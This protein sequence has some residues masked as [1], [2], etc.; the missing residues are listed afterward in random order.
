VHYDPRQP[1]HVQRAEAAD[2]WGWMVVLA[3]IGTVFIVVGSATGWILVWRPALRRRHA[4]RSGVVVLARVVKVQ[5]DTS[6]EANGQN[7][8]VIKLSGPLADGS[9]KHTYY[10]EPLWDDPSELVHRGD[11]LPV[12]VVPGYPDD[13]VVDLSPLNEL[14][15][16]DGSGE[17]ALTSPQMADGSGED[18]LTSPHQAE[19]PGTARRTA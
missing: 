2:R 1:T 7:P 12:R 6:I 3:I 8:W 14:Q 5:F 17:G 9:G 15:M 18:A 11:D 4:R 16:A 13:Y 19:S 10:S